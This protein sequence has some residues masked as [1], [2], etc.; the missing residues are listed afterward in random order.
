MEERGD[1][2]NTPLFIPCLNPDGMSKNTRTNSN[3][4]DLN[5]NFPTKNWGRTKEI[6]QLAMMK[7][8]IIMAVNL[9]QA[10]LKQDL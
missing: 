5:R 1:K 10:K 6:T 3:G 9:R 2:A 8:P 7:L 4:V